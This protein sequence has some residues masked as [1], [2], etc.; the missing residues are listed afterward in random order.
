[1]SIFIVDK[2]YLVRVNVGFDINKSRYYQVITL[3]KWSVEGNLLKKTYHTFLQAFR[4][5]RLFLF[6]SKHMFSKWKV[7][8][9]VFPNG[10]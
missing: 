7:T 10:N 9:E 8:D 6:S 1:M 2:M 4:A 5:F 3:F